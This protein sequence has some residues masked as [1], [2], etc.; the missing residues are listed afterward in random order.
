MFI[1]N[2]VLNILQIFFC[3][4]LIALI[5]KNYIFFIRSFYGIFG[6][7]YQNGDFQ[8]DDNYYLN[9]L[10]LENEQEK[11]VPKEMTLNDLLFYPIEDSN[12]YMTLFVLFVTLFI[13]NNYL[14]MNLSV[15]MLVFI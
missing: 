7:C 12:K 15:S 10:I 5:S 3:K 2:I 11:L 8:D 13:G 9:S 6:G 4:F 1:F 14:G